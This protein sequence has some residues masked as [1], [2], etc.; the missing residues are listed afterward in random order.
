MSVLS[1]L[2]NLGGTV[3]Q[4][5]LPPLGSVLNALRNFPF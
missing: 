2:L 5:L 1:N 3:L 4:P